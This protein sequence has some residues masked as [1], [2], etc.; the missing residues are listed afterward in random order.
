MDVP[1]NASQQA[2]KSANKETNQMMPEMRAMK[3]EC[4]AF[5]AKAEQ[6]IGKVKD[7]QNQE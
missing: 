1:I 3:E 2:Q 4:D 5:V 6:F 7:E